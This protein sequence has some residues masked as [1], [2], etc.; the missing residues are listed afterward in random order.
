MRAE[1]TRLRDVINL[2]G[3]PKQ[4][5]NEKQAFFAGQAEE[6]VSA[7]DDMSSFL[8]IGPGALIEIRRCVALLRVVHYSRL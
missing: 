2:A 6:A 1:E 5:S 7:E 8:E 3:T 4:M